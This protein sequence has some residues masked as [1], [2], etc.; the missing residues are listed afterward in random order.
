MPS[1]GLALSLGLFFVSRGWEQDKAV[2]LFAIEGS[3]QLTSLNLG[4]DSFRPDNEA[5]LSFMQ[6]SPSTATLLLL[7]TPFVDIFP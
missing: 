3:R 5:V 7:I 2:E 1:S 4:V 6:L